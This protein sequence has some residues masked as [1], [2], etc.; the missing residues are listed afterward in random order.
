[1]IN[2]VAN[3]IIEIND[4]SSFIYRGKPEEYVQVE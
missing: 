2:S 1:M 3:V 4:K